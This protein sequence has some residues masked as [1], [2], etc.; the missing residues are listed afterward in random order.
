MASCRM[1]LRLP[2]NRSL[3]P[4]LVT[5]G[6]GLIGEAAEQL[7]DM[8]RTPVK[9]VHRTRVALKQAR[10][11]LRLLEKAGAIW[12]IM[13][14]YRLAHLGGLM[15]AA[16]ERAVTLALAD[17]LSR[18]VRGR[19]RRV[20]VLLA[21]REPRVVPPD[22]EQIRLALLRES[23]EIG[24]APPPVIVPAQL[25]HLLRRSLERAT[26]RQREA[27]IRSTNE[28]MHEWRKAVIV[29]RDQ[30]RLAASRWPQGAGVAHP[31]LVRLARQLGRRGDLLLL[32]SRLQQLRVP[33]V[34]KPARRSLLARLE[35][36]REQ[37]T[38]TALLRWLRLVRRLVRLLAE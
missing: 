12:A 23:R 38:L 36:Q 29:L 28:S 37:A 19:E 35:K 6:A 5:L 25:R 30:T 14:R 1:K 8:T 13:P 18:K 7:A 33:A 4:G 17:K 11:T 24:L 34:L 9:S 21:P 26:S 31:L 10:S 16:R 27:V 15:S 3:G 20:A 32:L 2:R 22:F